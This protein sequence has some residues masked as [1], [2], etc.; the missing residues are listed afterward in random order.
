MGKK[1]RGKKE[2]RERGEKKGIIGEKR[3]ING[4]RKKKLETENRLENELS[5]LIANMSV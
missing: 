4:K 2:L 5:E 3:Q 1:E